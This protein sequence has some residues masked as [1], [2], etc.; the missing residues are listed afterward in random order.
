MVRESKSPALLQIGG[1]EQTGK[2]RVH[3]SLSPFV[4][5]FGCLQIRPMNFMSFACCCCNLRSPL[6]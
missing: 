2:F 5:L 1:T 4:S 3:I 6:R